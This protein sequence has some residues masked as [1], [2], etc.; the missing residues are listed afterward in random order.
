MSESP[1]KKLEESIEKYVK[2][3]ESAR[4]ASKKT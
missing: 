1:K 3:I 2:V 4:K